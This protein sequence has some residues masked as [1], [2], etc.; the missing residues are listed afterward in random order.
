[1]PKT[2]S[3][4]AH[5]KIPPAERRSDETSRRIL[6]LIF[7][8]HYSPG[9]PLPPERELAGT[10]HVSRPTLREA[11][12]RLEARGFIERRSKSGN[13]VCTAIPDRVREPIEAI[14][15]AHLVEF[16]EILEIRRVLELWAVARAAETPARPD[17]A[18]LE[19]CLR[20][21]RET[22]DL[23]TAERFDRYRE[24]DLR[25]HRILAEMTGNPIYVHLFDLL[26]HLI[27]KSITLS[28]QLVPGD[29]GARN[30]R[31]HEAVA[32]AVR[33]RD[34]ARARK[35]MRAHFQYVARHLLPKKSA[36]RG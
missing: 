17:L 12:N 5:G 33:A 16:A 29:F 21:M 1:M 18:S 31:T 14:V 26:D 4:P 23:R 11:L 34:A 25:F 22:S 2:A 32:D 28:R 15:E 10:L 6:A 36:K 19:E 20:V 13:Y 24:A 3:S 27:R 9:A 8:G 30:L 35:A 7:D